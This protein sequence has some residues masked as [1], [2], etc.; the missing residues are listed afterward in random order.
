MKDLYQWTFNPIGLLERGASRGPVFPLHLWRKA[1]VGFRPDWNR[2]VLSDLETFRSRRSLSALTPYLHGGVVHLDQPA[3]DP[4]RRQL[5]PHFHDRALS[6]LHER[7]SEVVT[8]GLPREEFDALAWA[9][10]IVRRMLNIAFFDGALPDQ[11]LARFLAPLEKPTPGALRPRPVLF[12]RMRAA[13]ESAMLSPAPHTLAATL[14]TL[15]PATVDYDLAEELRVALAAGYDTTAHTLAWA[16]WQLGGHPEW[17]EPSALPL[18]INEVLRLYPAG[19]LGSRTAARDTVAAGVPIARGTLV[20]YS[21]YLTHRD[22]ELWPDPLS[23]RPERF[24]ARQAPWTF[25]PFAA[26][27]R[28]CLGMHLARLMLTTALTPLCQAGLSAL[29]GNPGIRTSITLRP[30]GPLWTKVGV[31]RRGVPTDTSG[32]CPPAP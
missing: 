19:W 9:G 20:C 15:D 29:A 11:L 5:N 25:V 23:F 30:I 12:R 18:V 10:P 6:A 1:I 2:A 3:H 22:P 17:Q 8:A 4:R 24:T 27:S 14:R 16:I 7:L 13:I 32:R 28:T 26:G 21:P 31:T